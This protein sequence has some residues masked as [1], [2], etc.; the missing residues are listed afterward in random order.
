[1]SWVIWLEINRL[2]FSND[3]C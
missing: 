2:C 3:Q 1:V